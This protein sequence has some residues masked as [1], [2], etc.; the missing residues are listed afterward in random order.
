MKCYRHLVWGRF[1]CYGELLILNDRIL[2]IE[3]ERLTTNH[4]FLKLVKHLYPQ[5]V[6][7]IQLDQDLRF[8]S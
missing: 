6:H 1:Y 3:V 7:D 5:D 8:L 4:N 2:V